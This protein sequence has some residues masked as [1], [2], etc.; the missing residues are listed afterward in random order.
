MLYTKGSI[1]DNKFQIVEVIDQGG[2]SNIYIC[3]D[4]HS[5]E[6]IVLKNSK[7]QIFL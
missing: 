1:L 3:K 4:L 2:V 6:E 5:D 7:R